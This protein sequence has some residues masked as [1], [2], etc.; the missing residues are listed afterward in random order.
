MRTA[1][2]QDERQKISVAT[3]L[4]APILQCGGSLLAPGAFWAYLDT[5]RVLGCIIEV[6]TE[7]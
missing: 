3:R 2:Q 7:T 5:Q 4:D 6:K 1:R